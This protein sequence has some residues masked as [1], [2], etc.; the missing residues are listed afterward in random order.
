[1]GAL[2]ASGRAEVGRAERPE[3]GAYQRQETLIEV[4]RRGGQAGAATTR[5]IQYPLCHTQAQPD[6]CQ[7]P[8]TQTEV[9]HGGG[10]QACAIGR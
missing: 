8:S 7:E 10:G 4:P 5:W 6:H 3:C 9:G 1:M 2:P